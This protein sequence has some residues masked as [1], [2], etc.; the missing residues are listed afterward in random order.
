MKQHTCLRRVISMML[1][2]VMLCGMIPT[3]I[4]ADPAPAKSMTFNFCLGAAPEDVVNVRSLTDYSETRNWAYLSDNLVSEPKRGATFASFPDEPSGHWIAFKLKLN[5]T[6]TFRRNLTFYSRLDAAAI[7]DVYMIPYSADA[8]ANIANYMTAQYKTDSVDTAIANA[9]MASQDMSNFKVDAAGE[10]IMV[11]KST[12]K[13]GCWAAHMYPAVLTFKEAGSI[14]FEGALAQSVIAPTETTKFNVVA[15]QDGQPATVTGATITY[16]SSNDSVATVAN[17]STITAVAAGSADIT[18]NVSYDGQTWAIVKTITVSK[19]DGTLALSEKTIQYSFCTGPAPE[20]TVDI[21]SLTNYSEPRRWA[22]IADN[23]KAAP[24][25]AATFASIADSTGGTWMAVKLDITQAGTYARNLSFYSRSDA[26]AIIDMYMFPYSA[27]AV[28]NIANYMTA[29]NK[30]DTI[31][32]TISDK[33]M[34]SADLTSFTVTEPGEYIMVLKSVKKN[35][36]FAANMY[37]AVLKLKGLNITSVEAKMDKTSVNAGEST[38]VSAIGKNGTK[39]VDL[40]G[41][42]ISYASKNTDVATVD[43]ATGAI[44]ALH[45][46]SADITATVTYNGTTLT[47]VKTLTVTGTAPIDPNKLSGV[48]QE[49]KFFLK[50]YEG[51]TS[52]QVRSY[53]TYSDVR[54]WAYAADTF[55]TAPNMLA[56]YAQFP[57]NLGEWVAY[58]IKVPSAGTYRKSIKYLARDPSAIV[59]VFMAPYNGEDKAGITALITDANKCDHFDMRNP[60]NLN[61]TT[62][63]TDFKASTAGE[64][65]FILKIVGKNSW[66]YNMYPTSLTLDGTGIASAAITL[67]AEEVAIGDAVT[68]SASALSE[69]GAALDLS[70][71]T[72]T[73]ASSDTNVATVDAASGVITAKATG[74]TRISVTVTVDGVSKTASKALNVNDGKKLA[75]VELSGPQTLTP[76]TSG[77]LMLTAVLSDGTK[78]SIPVSNATFKITE[79]TPQNAVEVSANGMVSGRAIGTAKVCATVTFRGKTID[80]NVFNIT[81]EDTKKSGSSAEFIFKIVG[82]DVAGKDVRTFNDYSKNRNWAYVADNLKGTGAPATQQSLYLQVVSAVGEWV[83]LKVN[84]PEAGLYKTKISYLAREASAIMDIFLI[85]SAGVNPQNIEALLTDANKVDRIDCWRSEATKGVISS[86]LKNYYAPTAGEYILVFKAAGRTG[87]ASNM[88]PETFTLT[89]V[90]AI[91]KVTGEASKPEYNI[92][93]KGK[94][95]IHGYNVDNQEIAIDPAKAK[96]TYRSSDFAV[97]S[98][99]EDGTITANGIGECKIITTV[100]IGEISRECDTVINVT[101]TSEVISVTLNELSS[102]WMNDTAQITQTAQM[103]SGNTLNVPSSAMTYMIVSSSDEGIATISETG[104]ITGLLPGEVTIKGIAN[105]KGKQLE[106]NQIT[107]PIVYSAKSTPSLWTNEKRETMRENIKT[108]T[109]ARTEADGYV[110]QAEKYVGKESALWN[111]IVGEGIHRYYHVGEKYDPDKFKCRYC[112][113]DLLKQYGNYPWITDPLNSP[114]KI[115]C[116]SCRRKFPSNDF[117]SF[118]KAG[119]DEHGNFNYEKAKA[120]GK[121]FLKNVLY[122]EKD[123]DGVTGWGVDDGFGYLTGRKYPDGTQE[124]HTYIAYYLHFGVWSQMGGNTGIVDNALKTLGKAYLATGDPKYGRVGAILI[125]HVADVY[126]AFDWYQWRTLRGDTYRGKIVDEVWENDLAQSFAEAYDIFYPAFD[127]P[128]VISFL[129]N[130]ATQYK[131]DN[132]KQTADEIRKNC[133]DGILREINRACRTANIRGNFGMMQKTLGT[134]AV[135]LDTMPET[136]NWIEFIMQPGTYN[137]AS[138]TGGNVMA[139]LVNVIDRDGAGNEASPGYN[140]GWIGYLT[141]LAEALHGYDKVPNTDLYQNP[142]FAKQFTSQI[143]IIMASYYTMQIGDTGSA[144]GKNIAMSKENAL[145]GFARLGTPELAQLAYMLNNNTVDGLHMGIADKNPEKIKDDIK[146]IISE[147]GEFNLGSEMM[148]GYGFAALRDGASYKV[149]NASETQ[150]IQHDFSIYFGRGGGHGHND[151]LQLGIDAYGINMAPDLGYP[152]ATGTDANRMQWISRTLSHNTVSVNGKTQNGMPIHGKPIHFDDSGRVKVMDVDAKQVYDTT[153]IYRRTVVMIEVNKD[154]SY[155]VDF[156]RIKG[157]DD[158]IYSFHSQ[159]DEIYE[160]EGLDLV[161]QADAS[162]NYIGTYAGPDVPWGPDPNTT[163]SWT[164]DH[165]KYIPGSTWLGGVRRDATPDHKFAVDFKVKDFKKALPFPKDLHLRMTMLNNFDL[166]ELAIAQG[167]PPRVA[168]NMSMLEYVLARRTG[169]NLDTLYTTVFEPYEK[170]RYI[171][172]MSDVPVTLKDGTLGAADTAKAVKVV[173]KNGRID[174]IVYT[175]NNTVTYRVDDMFD[176]RG[177]VGVY[178]VMDGVPAFTYVNDGDIIGE[179][180]NQPAACTGIVT[181]YTKVLT[182]DNS[183][184]IRPNVP[185][186]TGILAGKH[187]YVENDGVEN[188]VYKIEGATDLG[189]GSVKLDIGNVTPIRSYRNAESPQD[190]YKYNIEAGQKFRIPL[191]TAVNPSPIFMPLPKQRAEAGSEL[192][193]TVSATSPSGRELTYSAN[194]LP[195]GG[196]FDPKTKT[197]TW[198]PDS[199]Q[200]GENFVAID[201]TDGALSERL[202][203][204]ITVYGSTSGSSGGG[205]GGGNQEEN[206]QNP[207]PTPVKD[208][209]SFSLNN[210]KPITVNTKLGSVTFAA[211]S[212]EKNGNGKLSIETKGSEIKV[213]LQV[214]GKD[215][216]VKEPIKASIGYKPEASMKDTKCIILRDANGN[217]I[218]SG[219][220]ENGKMSFY[221]DALGKFTVGYNEKAFEDLGNHAWASDAVIRLAARSIINGTSASTYTPAKNIT[222]ADFI[223]LVVRTFNFK[224]DNKENFNDVESNAYYADAVGIAKAL[225]I[226]TGQGDNRYNPTAEISREDMMVI[227]ARALKAEGIKIAE[228]NKNSFDDAGAVADYAQEAVNALTSSGIIAGSNGKINP[229]GKS[230]RAEIAVMLD[231]ILF[232]DK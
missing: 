56:G 114:F 206:G 25:R 24:T 21:R 41:A 168:G 9:K 217:I 160:T 189:N 210:E 37:P 16:K 48:M 181:D 197:F 201:V 2:A 86:D 133:E 191:P 75:S 163:N 51:D 135:V 225:G 101:D 147:N 14:T 129:N 76:I 32:T 57:G 87:W 30:T 58:K 46:G 84:I 209:A 121:D 69:S 175:T 50:A 102:V 204:A 109:W 173:H 73:Y 78:E 88:Y 157:G 214:D 103:K 184:T 193:F 92:G 149:A 219:K 200:I 192:K 89:G 67:S 6:G 52:D 39:T 108:Y 97:A 70:K 12:K 43:V 158:H 120:D 34:A 27:D 42:T 216:A 170:D 148:T 99:E 95:T 122:P 198:I 96:I 8:A 111:T 185:V 180:T 177:F 152:E 105:F 221:A 196:Q 83:A 40:T 18:A 143:P 224:A 28:A 10:Y 130:K 134:A 166:T 195:R 145:T 17:D 140:A 164:V 136:K 176:F 127:D 5:E 11:M 139:Q 218:P 63:L 60:T 72:V 165:L 188:G 231:R 132:K 182:M 112:G 202:Y 161:K 3:G 159:S 79:A 212:F 29:Q 207:V 110:K 77:Q 208:S 93:E 49:Y 85:P 15:K 123:V 107:V 229:K 90:N 213:S 22:Y 94:I 183:I 230:T 118:Y 54:P 68:A 62:I 142:K 7:I 172:D 186:D 81:V 66:G 187:I 194:K 222:R 113:A 119:L 47:A 20:T 162:G 232:A 128:Y 53:T 13:S 23:A 153:D 82:Q 211:G 190:G 100:T 106:T 146:K 126:P 1:I 215:M 36:C 74:S 64:Y 178:T 223:T 61:K 141:G 80:S 31:D 125:D 4:A 167:T 228:T 33:Q 131:M 156:F 154:V 38:S 45:E 169:K 71:A 179:N 26:A 138:C 226:V 220:F 65:L 35:G 59:D 171:A 144:A 115:Q 98:V 227:M 104:L 203:V 44:T 19:S 150:N 124:R 151:C 117:E 205:G 116:P 55:A 199:G 174:Y 137:G 91:A 155:G